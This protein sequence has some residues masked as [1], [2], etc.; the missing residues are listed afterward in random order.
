[1][2]KKGLPLAFMAALVEDKR[3]MQ[4]FAHMSAEEQNSVL[5][6]ARAAKSK[7]D[8]RLIVMSISDRESAVEYH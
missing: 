8:M 5:S 3:A 7:A 2:M 1:M 4:N 6:R